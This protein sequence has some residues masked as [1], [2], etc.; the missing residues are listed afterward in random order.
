MRHYLILGAGAAGVA[1]AES[2]RSRDP[3][4]Q[5]T[6]VYA[7][8]E[9]YYSRPGLAY[10]L[11]GEIPERQLFPWR[12]QDFQRFQIHLREG[13]ATQILPDSHEVALASGQRIAYDCLLDRKSVV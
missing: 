4:G 5:I 9:G 7:E 3:H 2:I 1:A 6:L 10:Y 8:R 11:T 12:K 13:R